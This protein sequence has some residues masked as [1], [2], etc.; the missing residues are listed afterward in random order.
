MRVISQA[1][2]GPLGQRALPL[3][4]RP[5]GRVNIGLREKKQ[6]RGA[7]VRCSRLGIGDDSAVFER[8]L[9][10]GGVRQLWVVSDYNN[11]QTVAV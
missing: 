8:D 9:A 5:V 7:I 11:A 6:A 10:V 3:T 4:R 2:S 1:R